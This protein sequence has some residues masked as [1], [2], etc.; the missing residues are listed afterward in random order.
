LIFILFASLLGG[1]AQAEPPA[2]AGPPSAPAVLSEWLDAVR[3]HDADRAWSLLAPEAR[4]GMTRAAFAIAF[5]RSW[6]LLVAQ[7]E[8]LAALGP[9]DEVRALVP[10]DAAQAELVF[11]GSRWVIRT[12]LEPFVPDSAPRTAAL[13]AARLLSDA[14]L[15]AIRGLLLDEEAR[16]VLDAR[17]QA[18][19]AALREAASSAPDD[20]DLVVARLP[21]GAVVRLVRTEHGFRLADLSWL[22]AGAAP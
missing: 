12:P 9:P 8:A 6:D 17:L 4:G 2:P 1:T 19:A 18:A 14:R 11:R 10:V 7:A 20:A 3:A 15:D 21:D 13:A 16:R 22:C 5:D